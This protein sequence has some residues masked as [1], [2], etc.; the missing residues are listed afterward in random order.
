MLAA[1][2]A[3]QGFAPV[4]RRRPQIAQVLRV[5]KH[6]Q[7]AQDLFFDAAEP[8]YE[9]TQPEFF[10]VAVAERS[11]HPSSRIDRME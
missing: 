6:V 1:P 3:C 7:F 9:L 2:A 8:L 5:V 11:D 10:G 4:R